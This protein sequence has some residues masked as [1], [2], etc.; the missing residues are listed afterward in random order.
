MI[1]LYVKKGVPVEPQTTLTLHRFGPATA[2]CLFVAGVILFNH[3]IKSAFDILV[4][5]PVYICVTCLAS[6][7]IAP[8]LVQ[9]LQVVPGIGS[10]IIQFR[11]PST[12]AGDQESA[13]EEGQILEEGLPER[14]RMAPPWDP[15]VFRHMGPP[16]DTEENQNPRDSIE[17]NSVVPPATPT[18]GAYETD[19]VFRSGG[20]ADPD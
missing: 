18:V 10:I 17:L 8:K 9:A 19:R 7:N 20:V 3:T 15:L 2:I 13:M 14:N 16:L 1:T 11:P 5:I 12:I 6:I 4:W